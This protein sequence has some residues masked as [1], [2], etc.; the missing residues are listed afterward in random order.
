MTEIGRKPPLRK[1]TSAAYGVS[2]DSIA[3]GIAVDCPTQPFPKQNPTGRSAG[4]KACVRHFPIWRLGRRY[5][6]TSALMTSQRPCQHLSR[7][8]AVPAGQI[9]HLVTA[10]GSGGYHDRI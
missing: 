9:S 1:T 10:A 6:L 8:Q 5:I 4:G 7:V 2:R 3:K